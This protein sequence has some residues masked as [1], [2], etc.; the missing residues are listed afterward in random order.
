MVGRSQE[1]PNRLNLLLD[2]ALLGA[3]RE[4]FPSYGSRLS[5]AIWDDPAI[6]SFY[7]SSRYFFG[8]VCFESILGILGRKGLH[9][10]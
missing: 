1:L 10:F 5:K 2:S 6:H 9:L 3:V 8:I 7:S 4:S